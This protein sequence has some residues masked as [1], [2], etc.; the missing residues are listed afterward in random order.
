LR[1]KGIVQYDGVDYDLYPGLCY[2]VES[3]VPH[4][5]FGGKN[6]SLVLL[7]CGD[8]HRALSDPTRLEVVK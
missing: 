4:A 8:N 6:D 1:G 5:I 3:N 7:V 2:L